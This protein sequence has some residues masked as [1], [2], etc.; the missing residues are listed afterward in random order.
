ML[1][2]YWN[3]VFGELTLMKIT[4]SNQL[5]MLQRQ[6]TY[7]HIRTNSWLTIDLYNM[8]GHNCLLEKLIHQSSILIPGNLLQLIQDRHP[9]VHVPEVPRRHP[10]QMP[11]AD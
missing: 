11:E 7:P 6:S 1:F 2:P 3:I 5:Y 4:I 10:D 8:I 9:D